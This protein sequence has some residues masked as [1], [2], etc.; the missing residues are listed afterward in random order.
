MF[1]FWRLGEPSRHYFRWS[2]EAAHWSVDARGRTSSAASGGASR[3]ATTA[4]KRSTW[5]RACIWR[6]A[7]A[8][9]SCS[10]SP[11]STRARSACSIASS[12]RVGQRGVELLPRAGCDAAGERR[13]ERARLRAH[14]PRLCARLRQE[15]RRVR[16]V[17]AEARASDRA[18][19]RAGSATSRRC[20]T[21]GACSK[22]R[23]RTCASTQR[24]RTS[25]GCA[26]TSTSASAHARLARPAPTAD[27]GVGA[28]R[29]APHLDQ[30]ARSGRRRF[31]GDELRRALS[32][33]RPS[34]DAAR[35][36]QARR[37][38]CSSTSLAQLLF[39]SRYEP[40]AGI[41]PRVSRALGRAARR[42][43]APGRQSGGGAEGG[44]GARRHR[45]RAR[46]LSHWRRIA[47]PDAFLSFQCYFESGGAAAHKSTPF[48]FA[49]HAFTV[50][51]IARAAVAAGQRALRRSLRRRRRLLVHGFHYGALLSEAGVDS[52][53]GDG[54]AGGVRR[55]R[56]SAHAPATASTAS[57]STSTPAVVA[58]RPDLLEVYPYERHLKNYVQI[59]R[60]Q[61][62]RVRGRL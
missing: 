42:V 54:T 45:R 43:R 57:T 44:V 31:R 30:P 11:A 40:A 10:R 38:R 48:T 3:S 22:A 19:A 7:S 20:T 17:Q 47:T 62:E 61:Y 14:A 4:A 25:P 26:A 58:A 23:G 28:A 13:S 27:A 59:F 9:R 39:E 29:V 46:A 6:C 49:G 5:G 34:A 52:G 37:A 8:S 53:A 1:R 60:R 41:V 21:R 50:E 55:P 12:M 15:P 18:P 32:L 35:R 24:D 36:R 2:T 33:A 56:L 16:A 51:E